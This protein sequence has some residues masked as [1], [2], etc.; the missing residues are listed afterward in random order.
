M[1]SASYSRLGY[2]RL[3][4]ETTAGTAVVPDTYIDIQAES[5]AVNF[6][7]E[8][9]GGIV[10]SRSMNLR[11]VPGKVGPFE[12]TIEM[13]VEPKTAGHF[14][15]GV[16]GEDAHTTHEAGVIETS[17]FEP[18]NSVPAYTVEIGR[19]GCGHADRFFGVRFVGYALSIDGNK[20][21]LTLTV[22][23]QRVFTNA[24]LTADKSSGTALLLDQTSGLVATDTLL[25]LDRNAP[26]TTL[27]ELT[28]GSVTDENTLVVST[29]SAA[30]ETGDICVIKA[31][32]P[33]AGDYD[34]SKELIF[35]GG[36]EVLF[37]KGTDALQRLVA[38]TNAESFDLTVENGYEAKWS[39]I[40]CDFV[41]RMPSAILMKSVGV[42]GTVG[43]FHITPELTDILR[44]GE[45]IGMRI[46][47]CGE[48]LDDNSAVA[49]TGRVKSDGAGYIT[50]T[51]D[52][53][54]EAGN[55]YAIRVVQGTD[56][57]SASLNGKMITVT[58]DKDVA[59]NTVALVASAINAL[60][61]VSAAE[62]GAGNVTVADNLSKIHLSGGLDANAREALIIDLPNVAMSDF[63]PNLGADD[64]LMDD[65]PF[66][67]Q[68]SDEDEREIEV[69][70]RNSVAAY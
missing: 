44:S 41:D 36:C 55:D 46:K 12:G 16:F 17:A 32:A 43:Q 69:R 24:R 59:D 54:G 5:I 26:G 31:Q 6:N 35:A 40:G 37:G 60:T 53:A 13:F 62:T 30:L 57:L 58:L 67:A 7:D 8:Q 39:A 65:V 50:V 49:A 10:G 61:G 20:L 33:I 3:K 56:T 70:L 23:C 4:K 19:A 11:K 1:N 18:K 38:R 42:S 25:I 52:A 66:T 68:R 29:I 21:K 34:L 22:S 15:C 14:L 64:T 51:A 27:A 63:T 28:V 9:I 47:F 48:T 45:T 2:L